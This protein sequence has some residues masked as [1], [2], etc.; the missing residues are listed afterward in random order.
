MEKSTFQLALHYKSFFVFYLTVLFLLSSASHSSCKPLPLEWCTL[1]ELSTATF[2]DHVFCWII[3]S[4]IKSGSLQQFL[5]KGFCLQKWYYPQK[6][7]QK[8]FFELFYSKLI[9]S[10]MCSELFFHQ[11]ENYFSGSHKKSFLK[12]LLR[13]LKNLQKKNGTIHRK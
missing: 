10:Q 13:T 12:T 1:F 8:R 5:L 4:Q 6:N 3:I 9:S 11:N 7:T 2:L